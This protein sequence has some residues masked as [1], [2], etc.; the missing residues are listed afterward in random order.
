MSVARAGIANPA[1]KDRPLP[2]LLLVV[3]PMR[4][5]ASACALRMALYIAVRAGAPTS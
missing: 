3:D 1:C 5:A 4:Q 2:P